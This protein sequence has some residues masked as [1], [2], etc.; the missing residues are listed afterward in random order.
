MVERVQVPNPQVPENELATAQILVTLN[1]PT[2]IVEIKDGARMQ[3]K[4][5]QPSGL[6]TDGKSL[7]VADS[8]TSS[9]RQ[10]PLVA[11]PEARVK[12]LVGRSLFVFGDVDGPGQVAEDAPAAKPEARVQHAL[13]VV[14]VNGKLYVAD[15]YNSKVKAFDLKSGELTTLVSGRPMGMFGPAVLNEPGGISYASGKLYVA[16]TN[17][18]RIRVVDLKTKHVSTLKLKGVEPPLP[19]PKEEP[20]K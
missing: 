19:P 12:T 20:K 8:E 14:H 5:A 18:H 3:A 6:T 13:G 10:L 11:D 7:F 4:F 15:T 9:I 2:R 1:G 16:D 17:A